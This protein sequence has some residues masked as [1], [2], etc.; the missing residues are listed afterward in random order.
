MFSERINQNIIETSVFSPFV[1]AV[2]GPRRV[3]KTTIIQHIASQHKENHWVFFN[4]DNMLERLRVEKQQFRQMIEEEIRQLLPATEKIWVVV[5]EAQKCPW[6][7]DQIKL[8]YDEFKGRNIIK[9]IITGSAYLDLHQLSAESLAGRIQLHYLQELNLRE[10]TSLVNQEKISFNSLFDCIGDIDSLTE[11]MHRL[12]PFRRLLE[13][14]LS[15]QW[16]W[17]GF[18]ECLTIKDQKEKRIYLSNYLQTYLE[19]D[20][21]SINTVSDLVRYHKLMEIIA[22]QTGSLRDDKRI[23]EALGLT[24]DTLNKYRSL[25]Q[26]TLLYDEIYPFIG[27]SLKRMVKSPKC[28]LLNNGLISLLTGL[29]EYSY[30]QSSGLIGHRMENWFLNELKIWLSRVVKYHQI[31]FWRTSSGAEV[32][33][34]VEIKPQVFPFEITCTSKPITKKVKSLCRFLQD[35]PKAQWG[36]YIYCGEFFVDYDKK[37]CFIPAWAIG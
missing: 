19:K 26:A 9:F 8:L 28:Y 7:F 16:V 15:Q 24:R 25:L 23:I 36:F 1:T 21:R 18:P 37:I 5:D 22:E 32:D 34:V 11:C 30:L 6:I 35:E 4:M 17:G 14:Q 13:E 27:S 29:D 2:L 3:G 20:V 33:F 12:T 31:Y 10:A